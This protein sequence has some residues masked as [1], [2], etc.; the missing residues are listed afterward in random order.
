MSNKAG[1][2]RWGVEG[3]A[4]AQ[5]LCRGQPLLRW[6]PWGHAATLIFKDSDPS[7]AHSSQVKCGRVGCNPGAAYCNVCSLLPGCPVAGWMA[8]QWPSEGWPQPAQGEDI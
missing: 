5:S 2:K 1:V 3:G 6:S 4:V 8:G 7:G